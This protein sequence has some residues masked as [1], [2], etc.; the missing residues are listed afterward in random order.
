VRIQIDFSGFGGCRVSFRPPA[1]QSAGGSMPAD[2]TLIRD[3]ESGH[4]SGLLLPETGMFQF[5]SRIKK[6]IAI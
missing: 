4:Y 2:L 6:M 5:S 3:I 1:G